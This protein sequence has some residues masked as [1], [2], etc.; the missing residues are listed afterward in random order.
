[1]LA[2]IYI[3]AEP[4]IPDNF[5]LLSVVSD[6]SNLTK[7]LFVLYFLPELSWDWVGYELSDR[8][9]IYKGRKLPTNSSFSYSS[10]AFFYLS[11]LLSCA[12]GAISSLDFL[13]KITS[14]N[15]PIISSVQV[16]AIL[17]T[18]GVIY[19]ALKLTNAS[20]Y[21]STS[22]FIMII[23]YSLIFIR[24]RPRCRLPS[25]WSFLPPYS[26][27]WMFPISFCR[28]K[29]QNM[30]F[31]INDPIDWS[32]VLHW[33]PSIPL[34]SNEQ[35][36]SARSSFEPSCRWLIS[37]PLHFQFRVRWSPGRWS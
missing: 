25:E 22:V 11:R 1:M 10:L 32:L 6:R 35:S 17:S 27:R 33:W 36:R 15:I 13:H 9:D 28:K 16:V 34:C 26:L 29:P 31:T 21:D 14:K 37:W 19:F 20:T 5:K 7:Y 3:T 12:I 24:S 2:A 30:L 18:I 4:W 23:Q 8:S